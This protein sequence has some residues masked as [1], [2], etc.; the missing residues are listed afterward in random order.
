MMST[1]QVGSTGGCYIGLRTLI[2]DELWLDEEAL[3][4]LE[5]MA[6]SKD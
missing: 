3:Q 6:N 4:Y 5:F 1:C 2:F